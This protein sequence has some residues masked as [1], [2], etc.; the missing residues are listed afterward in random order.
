MSEDE[1][2]PDT[3]TW[4]HWDR[5]LDEDP[6]TRRA[7]LEAAAAKL[8][9]K[10]RKLAEN[11]PL[12]GDPGEG[13]RMISTFTGMATDLIAAGE[14]GIKVARYYGCE[15]DP[16]AIVI[17]AHVLQYCAHNYP[18]IGWGSIAHAFW[19]PH[20]IQN[21]SDE[22][23]AQIAPVDTHV[24]GPPC[25]G[26]SIASGRAQGLR[27][28]RSRLFFESLRITETLADLSAK[29]AKDAGQ[30]FAGLAFLIENVD[31][32]N[33]PGLRKD[34]ITI[35]KAVGH[36]DGSGFNP[37]I[38]YNAGRIAPGCRVRRLWS[39]VESHKPPPF[40]MGPTLAQALRL[41]GD[42]HTPQITTALDH[43]NMIDQ[44]N[45]VGK[46]RNKAPT[47][48]ASWNSTNTRPPPHG[49]GTQLVINR[50]TGEAEK[51][52]AAMCNLYMMCP[53]GITAAPQ[54]DWKQQVH[55]QGNAMNRA[56]VS[57]WLKACIAERSTFLRQHRTTSSSAHHLPVTLEDP[58]LEDP[59]SE[60]TTLED[61]TP[62]DRTADAMAVDAGG[63]A[64]S[65]TWADEVGHHLIHEGPKSA[66]ISI[67]SIEGVIYDDT[68]D[69][70][71]EDL[72]DLTDLGK[73]DD[74]VIATP[75]DA[76]PERHA[77]RARG[78]AELME[79]LADDGEDM[80]GYPGISHC[81]EELWSDAMS[82]KI[83]AQ[84]AEMGGAMTKEEFAAAVYQAEADHKA[85]QFDPVP[86]GA[87]LRRRVREVVMELHVHRDGK[88]VETCNDDELVKKI[89]GLKDECLNGD[90]FQANRF[91]LHW[92]AWDELFQMLFDLKLQSKPRTAVQ[93][94]VLRWL[95][96]GARYEFW[97][98]S[99]GFEKG[100]PRFPEKH[101]LILHELQSRMGMTVEEATATLRGNRPPPMHWPNR[102]S[103][104]RYAVFTAN[105]LVE[106]IKCGGG[107]RWDSLPNR[108]TKGKPPKVTSGISVALRERDGKLRLCVDM[109][110]M[111]LWMKYKPFAFE[112]I[113]DV[114]LMMERVHDRG[115]VPVIC[116]SDAKSGYQH[117]PLH[118]DD[119]TY[120]CV[121]LFGM[122]IAY[123]S[124]TFGSTQSVNAY[125]TVKGEA[126]RAMRMLDISLMGYINDE[127]RVYESA[128]NGLW[129]ASRILQLG[130]ALG[131]Y[132]SF[133]KADVVDGKVQ[134]SKM[135]IWGEPVGE[136]LGF[137]LNANTR[138][139]SI[140][141]KKAT[142]QKERFKEWAHVTEVTKKIMAKAAG[143]IVSNSPA[144]SISKLLMGACFR[145][146]KGEVDWD[147][148]FPT[149]DIFRK[150]MW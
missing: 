43:P 122:P 57:H 30:P 32:A 116:S 95:K 12:R 65:V 75:L 141:L 83:A 87:E 66:P 150:L 58:I 136:S 93:A 9:A 46:P 121:E 74:T 16:V 146:M 120:S 149:P 55:V 103:V 45:E 68:T 37:G 24:S 15:I 69:S 26:F 8:L 139:I 126:R 76:E 40:R 50:E 17:Q 128:L 61:P 35:C 109:I 82:A 86:T 47:L 119:Y 118:E 81:Q 13:L 77:A 133:G 123:L 94:K 145:A 25:Q 10:W 63:E 147:D 131:E 142:Y 102:V 56:V 44:F 111:N 54:V 113:G 71:G 6:D 38:V 51:P 73:D 96:S 110:Y 3:G 134:F 124:L 11:T 129:Y 92:E 72:E 28:P 98:I 143:F 1:A 140:P 33:T 20:N 85:T 39:N 148:V 97:D 127:A 64:R 108:I 7:P 115:I 23:L 21:I 137:E 31:F 19:L 135:V 117:I 89:L 132:F 27:D 4:Q 42:T 130:T 125:C 67:D 2:D 104:E 60:D 91:A 79:I 78:V 84:D 90:N 105:T 34:Y 52:S 144:M 14:E 18:G 36:V 5:W 106:L 29:R 22:H 49:T 53:Q 100:S 88:A 114:I 107:A 62:E 112:G 48:V 70:D 101:K 80:E 138:T 59:I 41:C 99:S